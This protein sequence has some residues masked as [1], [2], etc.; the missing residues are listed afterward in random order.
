MTLDKYLFPRLLH[1]PDSRLQTSET[2]TRILICS[3]FTVLPSVSSHISSQNKKNNSCFSIVCH[4]I[5]RHSSL[6]LFGPILTLL[7]RNNKALDR[8][9]IVTRILAL[10]IACGYVIT[11]VAGR[12]ISSFPAFFHSQPSSPRR[13]ASPPANHLI[14]GVA[15]R[16]VSVRLTSRFATCT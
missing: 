6:N 3:H 4:C 13:Q 16:K 1:C 7:Q 15:S 11:R 10:D 12:S 5:T 8:K 14:L 2:L 9:V